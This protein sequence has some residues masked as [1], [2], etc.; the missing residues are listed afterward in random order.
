LKSEIKGD[1]KLI[2]KLAIENEEGRKERL[3]LLRKKIKVALEI[4]DKG[5][6][7]DH[8]MQQLKLDIEEFQEIEVV[9]R[10]RYSLLD[11]AYALFSAD[12]NPDFDDCVIP[13]GVTIDDAPQ[14]HRELCEYLNEVAYSKEGEKLAISMPRSFAKSTF[15]T[16]LFPIWVQVYRLE[17]ARFVVILSETVS[18]SNRFLDYSR[19][20]LKFHE[21]LRKMYGAEGAL[22]P[23]ARLNE[24]DNANSYVSKF[25][26]PETK[27]YFRC[28]VYSSGIFSQLRGLSFYSWRPTLIC[29]DDCESMK[30][31]N[32]AELREQA[33][34]FWNTVVEPLGNPNSSYIY[35]GTQIHAE[36]LLNSLM[37]RPSYRTKSYSA[38]VKEPSE[39]SA[40]L[41][42]KFEEIY[43]DR[44]NENREE[45][46]ENFFEQNRHIMESD[47]KTLWDRVPYKKLM[48][49]KVELGTRAYMSEYLNIPPSNSGV[50]FD[51]KNFLYYEP[52]EL[53]SQLEKYAFWDIAYTDKRTSDFNAV[54]TIGRDRRT[55]ILYILSSRIFKAKMH[56]A[57]QTAIEEANK[58][59]PRIFGIEGIAAQIEMVRQ[60]NQALI[61]SG[62]YNVKT[63][64]ILPKGKK[65]A[66]I[67]SLQ[68]L[69]ENG[70]IRF[71]K[72]DRLLIEQF[73]GYPNTH[74][75]GPDATQQCINL[76]RFKRGH[77]GIKTM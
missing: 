28:M 8:E 25:R 27:R 33:I 71:R 34:A 42:Q 75:D 62:I 30:S 36:S 51:E 21:R 2:C 69:I 39:K 22:E 18:M 61:S 35:I 65:Q 32:T 7:E 9:E 50:V 48:K 67:E 58:H 52:Q 57:L 20:S 19:N 46:A 77:L 72:E 54:I 64:S 6:L 10:C 1:Y 53:P 4:K 70:T 49:L 41:W 43:R 3:E 74:D 38:I 12:E 76:I 37:N 56:V 23:V 66:R 68:P 55:G 16:K 44:E 15:V 45:E 11:F 29:A 13:K 63:K 47:V 60:F 59:R 24:R 73:L 40:Q 14:V 31:T 17:V 26:N 5:L